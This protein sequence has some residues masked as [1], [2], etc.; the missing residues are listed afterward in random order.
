MV[1]NV[2]IAIS[3]H[4]TRIFKVADELLFLGVNADT[5]LALT[6]KAL[7]GAADMTKLQIPFFSLML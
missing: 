5:W 4:S 1:G 7:T 3:P 2:A 6:G